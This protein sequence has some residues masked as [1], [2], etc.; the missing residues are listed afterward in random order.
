MAR[1]PEMLCR[2][3]AMEQP[4]RD[5]LKAVAKGEIST[6]IALLMVDTYL[7]AATRRGSEFDWA[8]AEFTAEE[9]DCMS[10]AWDH[11]EEWLLEKYPSDPRFH[12]LKKG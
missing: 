8:E 3:N 10:E 7:A 11:Y 9:D 5:T 6:R 4:L 1:L 12:A 2:W